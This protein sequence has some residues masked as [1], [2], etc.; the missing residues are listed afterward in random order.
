MAPVYEG[1][2]RCD[3]E[4]FEGLTALQVLL[5]YEIFEN[6]SPNMNQAQERCDIKHDDCF[7]TCRHPF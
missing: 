1:K 6:E 7:C 4:F 3:R 5:N 2:M